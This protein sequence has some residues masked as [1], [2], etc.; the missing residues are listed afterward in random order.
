MSWTTWSPSPRTR[1][2]TPIKPD[3]IV[4]DPVQKPVI[5]S[6]GMTGFFATRAGKD[7]S[8]FG[9][10]MTGLFAYRAAKTPTPPVGNDPCV[11]PRPAPAL[12][13]V[14]HALAAPPCVAARRCTGTG[15]ETVQVIPSAPLFRNL[16]RAPYPVI[17]RPR[18]RRI[19][20]GAAVAVISEKILRFAQDDMFLDGLP[21][22][23]YTVGAHT[24]VRPYA[25]RLSL[26]PCGGRPIFRRVS[27]FFVRFVKS[28]T[29]CMG[30]SSKA[31]HI[32]N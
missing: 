13:P 22:L 4:S 6:R 2:E 7:P 21:L 32:V 12:S 26:V 17:L 11:V 20:F 3:I 15:R 1:T 9:L 16:R 14:R 28:V 19:Y 27:P 5:P 18:G 29:L 25:P 30:I 31:A 23:P 24:Q 8:A 10:G